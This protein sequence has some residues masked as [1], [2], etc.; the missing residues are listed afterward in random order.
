MANDFSGDNRIKALWR[1]EDG[2][3][4]TDSKGTNTLTNNN[5]SSDTGDKKEGGAC[6]NYVKSNSA[7]Q[8]ITDANLNAGFPFKNGDLAKKGFIAY[9][10]KA[11]A[12]TGSTLFPHFGKWD[13]NKYSILSGHYGSTLRFYWGKGTSYDTYNFP[14]FTLQTGRWYHVAWWID[15][16][17][18]ILLCR[19]YDDS[20]ATSYYASFGVAN[21]LTAADADLELGRQTNSTGNLLDGRLDEVVVADDF[22]S[23]PEADQIRAG[24]FTGASAIAVSQLA[25][26]VEYTID[27]E[28]RVTQ[29]GVQVEYIP[30]DPNAHYYTGNIGIS[31]TPAGTSNPAWSKT[32]DIPVAATP[33]GEYL[34]QTA[35]EFVYVGNIAISVAPSA[36]SAV[37][38]VFKSPGIPVTIT[39]Q[40]DSLYP[41]RFYES[42][43]IP[44]NV[45]P[46]GIYR[47]P[48]AGF[49]N[50]SGYGAVDIAW[51]SENPPFWVPASDIQIAFDPTAADYLLYAEVKHEAEGGVVVSGESVYAVY[52]PVVVSETG[53]GGVLIGGEAIIKVTRPKSI[54]LTARGGVRV[55]GLPILKVVSRPAAIP[56]HTHIGDGG[57]VIGGVPVLAVKRP[58]TLAFTAQ[59]GVRVGGFYYPE[60]V[61]TRP[62]DVPELDKTRVSVSGKGGVEVGGVAPVSI[63]RP[64]TLTIPITPIAVVVAGETGLVI[65]RPQT[66]EILGDGGLIIGEEPKPERCDTWVLCDSRQEPSLYTGFNFNSYAVHQGEGYAA[67]EDGIY[68]LKG[69]DDAG[70]PI[71]PGIRIG[72]TNFRL[73]GPKRLR[74]I[75][76]NEG[77]EDAEVRVETAGR[78]GFFD[79]G[80]GGWKISRDLKGSEFVI[81]IS[82]F[83]EVSHFE[84]LP[85]ILAKR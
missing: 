59:G 49:D 21:A 32:G 22:L 53:A 33:E 40:A 8:V 4:T 17:N 78:S 39:P 5:V 10:L 27:P 85:L 82:D 6:G 47:Q 43:G 67:A 28:I 70:R 20:T 23:L 15:G 50:L 61:I 12:V 45:A 44:I 56:T 73:D 14:G 13:A 58:E 26:D 37:G 84:V 42:Q 74:S 36:T 16:V 80:R 60:V 25:L 52:R 63:K 41:V 9:W 72:K 69:E 68:L 55:G 51:L 64:P 34:Y 3:L 29:L 11:A 79:H 62:A 24:T 30:P 7:Y 19:V 38:R 57:A 83:K 65:M 76:L 35:G 66:I 75:Y 2:A 54:H 46:E 81:D 18:K 31:V 71:R 48:V 77:N 1:H